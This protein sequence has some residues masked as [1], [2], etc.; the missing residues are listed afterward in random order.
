MSRDDSDHLID[1]ATALT[2]IQLRAELLRRQLK[3]RGNLTGSDQEWLERGLAGIVAATR[4][5]ALIV[6]EASEGDETSEA[7]SIPT[8]HLIAM[9]RFW[10]N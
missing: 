4:D 2:I 3:L 9:N 7:D 6:V 8:L 5:L 1:P 10:R